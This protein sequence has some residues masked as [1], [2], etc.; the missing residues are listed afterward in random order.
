LLFKQ[1]F[2]GNAPRYA[3]GIND[4][5]N[6]PYRLLF[7]ELLSPELGALASQSDIYL[8]RQNFSKPLYFSQEYKLIANT[9]IFADKQKR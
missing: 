3:V 7:R 4:I 8:H 6:Y 2:Y 5:T 9:A 1:Q